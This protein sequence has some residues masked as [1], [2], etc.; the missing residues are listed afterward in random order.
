MEKNEEGESLGFTMGMDGLDGKYIALYFTQGDMKNLTFTGSETRPCSTFTERLTKVYSDL[1][2]QG[3]NIEIVTLIGNTSQLEIWNKC[4]SWPAIL[5][6][7]PTKKRALE[8]R[9]SIFSSPALVILAPDG[10]L[11]CRN[12]RGAVMDQGAD[13]FPWQGME[14]EIQAPPDQPRNLQKLSRVAM[15]ILWLVFIVSAG[16]NYF[17]GILSNQQPAAMEDLGLEI[18][19]SQIHQPISASTNEQSEL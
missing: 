18:P 1:K 9:W 10:T 19:S 2:R 13:G 11:C 6:H 17:H 16:T 12:A 14:D 4:H 8:Q 5:C 7:G 3:K 15:I